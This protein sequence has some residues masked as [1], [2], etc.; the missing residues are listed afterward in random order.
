MGEKPK[1]TFQL[2]SLIDKIK[3]EDRWDYDIKFD[4]DD[5]EDEDHGGNDNLLTVAVDSKFKR[6]NSLVDILME[7][8]EILFKKGDEDKEIEQDAYAN[9]E[10]ADEDEPKEIAVPQEEVKQPL[11]GKRTEKI[12]EVKPKKKKKKKSKKEAEVKAVKPLT[13]VKTPKAKKKDVKSP[14]TKR[15]AKT[16][17]SKTEKSPKAPKKAKGD[18]KAKAAT[19]KKANDGAACGDLKEWMT[20]NEIY[21]KQLEKALISHGIA[22]SEAIKEFDQIVR[23]IRVERFAKVKGKKKQA[24]IDEQL[25]NLE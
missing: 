23:T 13:D 8:P 19:A 17:V 1:K 3:A 25:V 20:R 9:E 4:D 6:G 7:G 21:D 2:K 18:K 16:P 14:K 24:V 22:S 5:E 12:V 15:K 10:K 11:F